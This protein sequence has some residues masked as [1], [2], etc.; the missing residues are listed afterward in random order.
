M[1]AT[2]IQHLQNRIVDVRLE[3]RK[4]PKLYPILEALES[5]LRAVIKAKRVGKAA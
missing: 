5:T 3:A 4:N 2:Q 1:S